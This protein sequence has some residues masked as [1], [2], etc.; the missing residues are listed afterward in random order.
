VSAVDY[1]QFI[2]PCQH[3]DDI[4]EGGVA[5]EPGLL[6]FGT[7]LK[8]AI[9]MEMTCVPHGKKCNAYGWVGRV[10]E[11]DTNTGPCPFCKGGGALAITPEALEILEGKLVLRKRF[12][13]FYYYTGYHSVIIFR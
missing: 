8:L 12:R 4:Q 1:S 11:I 6:H 13:H 2:I 7:G 3:R 9:L 10:V 5:V